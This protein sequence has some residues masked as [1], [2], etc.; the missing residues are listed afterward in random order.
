M[1]VL[2]SASEPCASRTEISS[3]PSSFP[4]LSARG[5][6]CRPAAPSVQEPAPGSEAAADPTSTAGSQHQQAVSIYDGQATSIYSDQSAPSIYDNTAPLESGPIL[7]GSGGPPLAEASAAVGPLQSAAGAAVG[8]PLDI[9]V[10]S[11]D[12]MPAWQQLPVHE[13]PPGLPTVTDSDSEANQPAAVPLDPMAASIAQAAAMADMMAA[14][15]VAPVAAVPKVV[16]KKKK[17]A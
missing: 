6:W 7:P 12:A 8:G 1:S 5:V 9:S 2:V 15:V 11:S 17:S 3:F 14:T 16:K 13:A 10:E 4:L